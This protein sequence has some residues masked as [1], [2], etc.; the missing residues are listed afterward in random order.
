[1]CIDNSTKSQK[2]KLKILNN[3]EIISG[4]ALLQHRR[5]EAEF[6]NPQPYKPQF[7]GENLSSLKNNQP[8]ANLHQVSQPEIKQDE[9]LIY[10]KIAHSAIKNHCE[11][12]FRAW[13]IAR[14]IDKAGRGWIRLIE[15]KNFINNNQVNYQSGNYWLNS[16][17]KINWLVKDGKTLRILSIQKVSDY[18]GLIQAEGEYTAYGKPGIIYTRDFLKRKWHAAA[19]FAGEKV[20]FNNKVIS[21][22]T[23]HSLG[24]MSPRTQRKYLKQTPQV[25]REVNFAKTAWKADELPIMLEY[26]EKNQYLIIIDGW[27]YHRLPNRLYIPDEIAKLHVV[28]E[29]NHQSKHLAN[30]CNHKSYSNY[31]KYPQDNDLI[32]NYK[33]FQKHYKGACQQVSKLDKSSLPTNQKPQIFFPIHKKYRDFQLWDYLQSFT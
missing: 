30:Y 12:A 5:A 4:I 15:Y 16:A 31:S 25:K 27:I 17:I 3:P 23:K 1:M 11:S 29:S 22:K 32:E 33:I 24:F 13:A 10:H 7:I 14:A 28:M 2:N 21:Q 6:N 26:N 18:L 19:H 9:I 8:S 20:K